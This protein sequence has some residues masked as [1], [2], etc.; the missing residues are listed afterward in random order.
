M[1]GDS[2]DQNSEDEFYLNL[3]AHSRLAE[4]NPFRYSANT[5]FDAAVKTGDEG[6]QWLVPSLILYPLY[7]P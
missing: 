7:S 5:S 6:I 1:G 4:E 2:D 3:S